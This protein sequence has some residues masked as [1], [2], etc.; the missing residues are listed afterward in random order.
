[1]D[2]VTKRKVRKKFFNFF[3][4]KIVYHSLFW[5][6]VLALLFL[7]NSGQRNWGVT[8]SA[9]LVNVFFYAT[10]VYYNFLYLIPNYLTEKKFL[11]YGALLIV[12]A[13][14]LAPIKILVLYFLFSNYPNI[15]FTL[16]HDQAY[17]FLSNFVVAGSS[18]IVKIISDWAK[19]PART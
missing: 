19:A 10:I 4:R 8:L 7:M 18:T 16:I 13:I 17:F 5:L 3:S 15:Q 2:P 1:M 9:E 11:V 12:F 6:V 14:I